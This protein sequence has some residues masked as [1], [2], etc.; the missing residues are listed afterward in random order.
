MKK[1]VTTKK[2]N[3]QRTKLEKVVGQ[4]ISVVADFGNF[5]KS[6][7]SLGE[8]KD[9]MLLTNVRLKIGENICQHIWVDQK[10]IKNLD[11]YKHCLKEGW[12]ISLTGTPYRYFREGALFGKIKQ[13]KYSL[14]NMKITAVK[15]R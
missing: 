9:T 7:L 14:G 6:K 1:G 13:A 10:E 12:K 4:E 3:M 11:K 15:K 8:P 2:N 5:G